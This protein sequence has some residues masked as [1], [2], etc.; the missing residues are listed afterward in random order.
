MILPAGTAFLDDLTVEAAALAGPGHWQTGQLGSAHF[1]V[2]ALEGYRSEVPPDDPACARYLSAL[3][4]TATGPYRMRVTGLTLTPGSV[5]AAAEPVDGAADEFMDRLA[6]ELG[7]DGWFERPHGRR[8]IWYVN[9]LHFTGDITEP[10]KLI[11]WVAERRRL[12]PVEV[13]VPAAE[14]V[15]FRLVGGER[16]HMRPV[17]L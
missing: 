4:R 8:D 11:D 3:D 10:A 7:P 16:P 17:R 1:T 13:V 9:L 12:E 5:M 15:R 6:L 14:L 2:R